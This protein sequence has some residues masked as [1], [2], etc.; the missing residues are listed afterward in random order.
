MTQSPQA[1]T[2]I[3]V[4]DDYLDAR[5]LL[6]VIFESAGYEVVTAIDGVGAVT[7]AQCEHPDIVVMDIAMPCMD[8]I[9]ATRL[10]RA[11]SDTH[12][13]PVVA[14]SAFATL[15]G[16]EAQLFDAVCP[17]PCDPKHLLDIV[18]RLTD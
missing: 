11:R 15:A 4:V 18:A 8:G 10:I 12:S 17:K 9:E 6:T 7:A 13:I 1:A 16:E 3:L 5:E 14:H 2:R